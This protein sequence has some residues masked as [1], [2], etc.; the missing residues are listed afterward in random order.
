MGSHNSTVLDTNYGTGEKKL[1]IYMLG[2]FICILLTLVPFF[3]VIHGYFSY[4]TSMVVI[5]SAAI[6]QFLTQIICFLRLNTRTEQSQLNVLA[7][8]FTL[9]VLLVIVIASLW[10]MWTLFHRMM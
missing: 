3:T 2:M 8:V 7:F 5:F 9:V 10:I 1:S 6:L 4:H